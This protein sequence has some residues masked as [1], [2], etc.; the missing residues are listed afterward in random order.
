M[1]NEAGEPL[2]DRADAGA[3]VAI[4]SCL[5]LEF[6]LGRSPTAMY[7]ML[8]SSGSM[9]E[10]NVSGAS[11]WQDVLRATRGFMAD[12]VDSEL[13]MGV[14][15]FPLLKPGSAHVCDSHDDCGPDGG[16]CFLS[17][18]AQSDGI[19]LCRTDDDC[20][21][22]P[23]ENPCIEFGLCSDSD[24]ARPLACILGQQCGDGLGTCEDFERTCTDATQ[25]DSAAYAAPAVEI[26]KLR[27]NVTRIDR[28][29]SEQPVA[30]LTPVGPALGGAID[31]ATEWARTHPEERVVAV[32]ATD[33]LPS[34]CEP[35]S[36]A[37]VAAIAGAAG[38]ALRTYVIGTRAPEQ[39][40][41]LL[42][43][44]AIAAAGGTTE[45]ILL[46]SGDGLSERFE[47]AI[48]R[49]SV[50]CRRSL[51]TDVELDV[52]RAEALLEDGNAGPVRLRRVEN[53]A[54][55]ADSPNGWFYPEDTT[56]FRPTEA[57]LCPEL[58][59]RLRFT[60]DASVRL[61]IS[62]APEPSD[63][64]GCAEAV[65]V[66][67]AVPTLIL[68]LD[69]SGSMA[70]TFD[71][72][73]SRWESLMSALT[74]E[75]GPLR[76]QQGRL[77]LGV[78]SYSSEGGLGADPDR[79]CPTLREAAPAIDNFSA[80]EAFLS[81]STPAGDSPGAESV[82][83]LARQTS[84]LALPGPKAMLWILD[85]ASDTCDD[86]NSDSDPANL[87]REIEA[88]REAYQ[89][90]VPT[91]VIGMG[92]QVSPTQ[93]GALATAGGGGD[94]TARGHHA[95][96][97]AALAEALEQS[98]AAVRC[99]LGLEPRSPIAD[100]SRLQVMLGDAPLTLGGA[101]GWKLIGPSTL[102]LLGGACDAWQS[103]NAQV[104]VRLPCPT[105]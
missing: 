48:A 22:T 43:L 78:A 47:A 50:D 35:Q 9:V 13:S 92:D 10:E 91:A 73:S 102:Q 40:P 29:M 49:A 64:T 56:L 4:A 17:T 16:L 81:G 68:L 105:D 62:C 65:V 52:F 86:V 27:D 82:A 15:F 53:A 33:G 94:P 75:D 45:A 24:P 32:L 1:P 2:A 87:A 41:G 23:E 25:C 39:E 12:R 58:C 55:C 100:A 101:D 90:G 84:S 98:V 37:E 79:Q 63:P 31:H 88:V 83:L 51:V 76:R 36:I 5:E 72:D 103:A 34:T 97:A 42:N 104:S 61:R 69:Q 18:C 20:P 28:A 71:D 96:S 21:G 74:A 93:L 11:K 54:A 99:Q 85:G 80:I 66:R 44:H 3:E 14:Q 19:T 26:G 70:Q 30:G 38:P 67:P 59:R 95:T 60:S 89:L 6:G 46:E 8:D 7:L 77:R 57:A